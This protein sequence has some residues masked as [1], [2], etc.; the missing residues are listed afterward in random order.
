MEDLYSTE[1][2]GYLQ[3]KFWTIDM[4]KDKSL[5]YQGR[6]VLFDKVSVYDMKSQ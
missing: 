4:C 2:Y 3:F 5:Q 6:E 1:T